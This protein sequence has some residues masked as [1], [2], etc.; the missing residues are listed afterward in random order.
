[1]IN[2]YF[3]SIVKKEGEDTKEFEIWDIARGKQIDSEKVINLNG[4]S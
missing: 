1:M 4:D 3:V 2:N